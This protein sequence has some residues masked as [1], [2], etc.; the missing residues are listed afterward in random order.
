MNTASYDYCFSPHSTKNS[1]FHWEYAQHRNT[2]S[3]YLDKVERDLLTQSAKG[4]LYAFTK[5]V[6]NLKREHAVMI[7][8]YI[9]NEVLDNIRYMPVSEEARLA[10]MNIYS[11]KFGN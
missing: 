8:R 1:N 2:M 10:I 3:T 9:L 6:N 4:A 5:T 11:S 7:N